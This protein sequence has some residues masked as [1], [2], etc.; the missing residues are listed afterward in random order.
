MRS[1]SC[2]RED[3]DRRAGI[4]SAG[5]D[6]EDDVGGMDAV[7]DRLGTDRLDRR[8]AVGEYRG[9]DVDHLP[10]AV[11]G[12]GELAPTAD[13]SRMRSREALRFEPSR[14]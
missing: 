14:R 3:G 11:V 5:Q 8:Q 2:G 10:V 4:A 9:E 12:A 6:V 13:S 1:K 7:G